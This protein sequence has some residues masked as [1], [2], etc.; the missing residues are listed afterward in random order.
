MARSRTSLRSHPLV[1]AA[2]LLLLATL[3]MRAVPARA[4]YERLQEGDR[5]RFVLQTTRGRLTS[6]AL[7]GRTYAV[8]FWNS[9]STK[10]A[11]E[12]PQLRSLVKQRAGQDFVLIGY[13]VDDSVTKTLQAITEGKMGWP[14]ALHQKQDFP[15]YDLFYTRRSPVP[16]AFLVSDTGQLSWFGPLSHLVDQVEAALPAVEGSGPDPRAARLAAQ[17]AYRELLRDPPDAPRLLERLREIPDESWEQD[18]GVR[19]NLRRAARRLARLEDDAL[20][21]LRQ[22]VTAEA[23]GAEVFER[24]WALRPELRPAA[25]ESDADPNADNPPPHAPPEDPSADAAEA[26]AAARTA[27]AEGD[28]LTAWE[29]YRAAADDPD[30]GEH[31]P[32]A[33]SELRRL[34]ESAGFAERL[35]AARRERVASDLYVKALNL[36]AAGE[37]DA[38]DAT[39]REIRREYHDTD[40]AAAAERALA[41]IKQDRE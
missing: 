26:L 1:C 3:L 33:Q 40:A 24:L 12:L 14:Q 31:G 15:F 38:A 32:V 29:R 22:A 21:A 36:M 41:Q 28:L 16:G 11:R 27:D 18:R 39:L 2:G 19:L 4:A 7:E 10:F 8:V 9:G 35:A 34:E 30:A 6:G 17:S 5:V 23:G 37:A 25:P 13:N 20:F